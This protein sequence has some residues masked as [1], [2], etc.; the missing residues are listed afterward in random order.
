MKR[1]EYRSS[2]PETVLLIT[3]VGKWY[4]AFWRTRNSEE[5][6]C[7]LIVKRFT[8]PSLLWQAVYS[9]KFFSFYFSDTDSHVSSST[10]VR[11]Y[12]HDVVGFSLFLV[13]NVYSDFITQIREVEVI[14]Y[15]FC[16]K[17]RQNRLC[18]PLV[19]L[20]SPLSGN[21]PKIPWSLISYVWITI[22]ITIT[23]TLL[24]LYKGSFTHQCHHLIVPS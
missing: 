19:D 17:L 14:K 18:C 12:P 15:Q 21:K 2:G 16:C 20:L 22:T 3:S 1:F 4:F 23:I 6:K 5:Y 10:S 8:F 24:R 13:N 7:H 9:L 11:F